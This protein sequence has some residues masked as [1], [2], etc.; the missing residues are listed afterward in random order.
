MSSDEDYLFD[1]DD[2]DSGNESPEQSDDEEDWGMD[3]GL[4]DE[5]G[6]SGSIEGHS[7]GGRS[8]DAG[9]RGDPD[10]YYYE[11]L[12]TE[13]IVQHMVDTI[14]EVNNVI[15]I[16]PTTVRILLNHFKWDKEK[17]MERYYSDDAE[18][19]FE[20]AKVISP[21]RKEKNIIATASNTPS[22]AKNWIGRKISTSGS[23]GNPAPEVY[24]CEICFLSL[25]RPMMA[26]LEWASI[27]HFL[28]D[29]IPHDENCG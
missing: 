23:S 6:P 8:G 20:E 12:S 29:R 28:L 24:D 26:G 16:P 11:V 3:I 13:Q 2:V 9:G 4:G 19:M 5:Q 21:N 18:K 27:L 17:L 22:T 15:Q 25:P 7:R 1:E 14:A 10:D